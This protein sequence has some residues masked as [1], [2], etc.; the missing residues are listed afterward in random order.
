MQSVF[1]VIQRIQKVTRRFRIRNQKLVVSFNFLLFSKKYSFNTF[2][3]SYE[4]KDEGKNIIQ[5]DGIRY[6]KNENLY[7]I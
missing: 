6:L 3:I 2:S 1:Q 7:F 4:M 5:V